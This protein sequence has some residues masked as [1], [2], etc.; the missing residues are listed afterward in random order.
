MGAA[1]ERGLPFVVSLPPDMKLL[2]G[3]LVDVTILPHPSS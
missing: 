3:E 2:P 1:Q